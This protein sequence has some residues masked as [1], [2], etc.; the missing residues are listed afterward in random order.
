MDDT[1]AVSR[2]LTDYV[3]AF[4]TLDVQAILPYYHEPCLLVGPQGVAALPTHAAMVAAFTPMMEGLRAR[5]YGHSELRMLHIKQLSAT[6]VLASGVAVRYRA[7]GQELERVGV[8]YV[9]H[10]A[11]AD[12]RWTI[13]VTMIHDTDKVVRPE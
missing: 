2:V 10:K 5:G 11:D 6:A 13:A 1:A 3:S 4:G 12:D 7:D 8:S 9:L